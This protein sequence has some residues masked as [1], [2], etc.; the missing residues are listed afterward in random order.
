MTESYIPAQD[1]LA[2]AWME[3][4]GAGL[5]ANPALYMVTAADATA[6][7]NAVN[8]FDAALDIT[9]DPATKTKV[10]VANKDNARGSAEQICRQFAKLIKG[11]RLKRSMR[12]RESPCTRMRV[13]SSGNF[14]ILRTTP[15]TPKR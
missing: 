10:T 1:T 9:L 15:A 14:I 13:V 11:V 7:N 5:A 12:T 8:A 4:F 2:L 3:V 6:V